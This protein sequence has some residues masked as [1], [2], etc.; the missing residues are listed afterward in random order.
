MLY[1]NEQVAEDNPTATIRTM[2]L[3]CRSTVRETWRFY[4]KGVEIGHVLYFDIFAVDST[5][6]MCLD[7]IYKHREIY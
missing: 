6:L 3:F 2:E 4:D 5:R 7:Q 1:N